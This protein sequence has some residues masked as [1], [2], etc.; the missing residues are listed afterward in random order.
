MRAS[1]NQN[2]QQEFEMQRLNMIQQQ[3]ST[4][5]GMTVQQC[6]TSCNAV[7]EGSNDAEQL[8]ETADRN[9]A[10]LAGG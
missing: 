4:I 8:E 6:S 5:M 9:A 3:F 2:M 7:L 10:K 1:Q